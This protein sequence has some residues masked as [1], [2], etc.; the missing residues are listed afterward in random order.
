MSDETAEGPTLTEVQTLGEQLR[1]WG[2]WGDDD[3]VGTVNHVTAEAIVRSAR[4]VRKGSVFTL[5]LPFDRNLPLGVT[6]SRRFLPIHMML[7][8]GADALA[9]GQ[10]HLKGVRYSD[11]VIIMPL[12]CGT[13]W[14]GLAHNFDRE[15][16]YNGF[17]MRLVDGAGARRNGI[18]NL[19][20]RVV[21]RGVLLDV[22]RVLGIPWME[23]GDRVTAEVL[24]RCVDTQEVEVGVGDYVLVRTGHMA[25]C[26]AAG[27]W[28]TY[29]GG[30]APGLTLDTAA[31]LHERDVAAVATDTW[32][33]EVRPNETSSVDQPWHIVAISNMG[34][35]VGEIFDLDALA[36]D[37]ADDD[38][39]E[40]LFVA[41][42][43]PFTGAV[44]SPVN[45]LAIK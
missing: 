33:A 36:D 21:G 34:L 13:Q 35:L 10:E 11:D 22:P 26:R 18:Q 44:G 43:L 6:G 7:T 8:S 1:N 27:G 42:P 29:S 12:Q 24:Q 30:H 9:G 31:W 3:E 38:V 39:H 19:S 20:D 14:D 45:P 41:P 2:R 15:Q 16:M 37:C 40:F 5:A 4:L 23:P 17:D 25:Q 32:G 28:G